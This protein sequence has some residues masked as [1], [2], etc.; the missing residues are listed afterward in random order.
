M[1]LVV[2]VVSA[3]DG[4]NL[5]S[6][7][8]HALRLETGGDYFSCEPSL[9]VAPPHIHAGTHRVPVDLQL[10]AVMGLGRWRRRTERASGEG[11]VL[12]KTRRGQL[13]RGFGRVAAVPHA[14]SGG[15]RRSRRYPVKFL[16]D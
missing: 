4:A 6:A 7:P 13:R 16:G 10:S 1:D 14:G 9:L 8:F 12:G 11:C 15:H 2:R 5:L 3:R